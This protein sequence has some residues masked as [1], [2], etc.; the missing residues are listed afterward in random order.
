[1]PG[2]PLLHIS[3]KELNRDPDP[4]I[5]VLLSIPVQFWVL[6]YIGLQQRVSIL[7]GFSRVQGF[8]Y[9]FFGMRWYFSYIK[10]CA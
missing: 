6:M 8:Q 7:V 4:G 10:L 5:Q 9:Y 1:M 3:S 2:R